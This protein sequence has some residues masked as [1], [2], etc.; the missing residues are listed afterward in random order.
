MTDDDHFGLDPRQRVLPPSVGPVPR[1]P[2]LRPDGWRPRG[3]VVEA[4]PGESADKLYRRFKRLAE[5][6]AVLR[7][8]RRKE[9]FVPPSQARRSKRARAIA[10]RKKARA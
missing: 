2:R 3:V 5:R 10:R 1:R 8:V 9:H 4:L 7:D 6:E